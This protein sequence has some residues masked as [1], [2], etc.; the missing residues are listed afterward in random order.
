MKKMMLLAAFGLTAFMAHSQKLKSDQVPAA[1]K[2]SFNKRFPKA[3]H[4]SWSKES[5]TEYEAEFKN[6]GSAQSVNFDPSG[7]W[8]ETETEIKKSA[9]PPEV[10][11]TLAKEFPGYKVEEPEL[12]ETASNGTLYETEV[13]NGKVIYEVQISKEGKL[14]R[15]EEKKEHDEKD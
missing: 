10:Q 15:K 5:S 11:A 8:I 2:D 3:Q 1:V 9:L 13:E 7:T 6:N 12:S 14:I 4:V